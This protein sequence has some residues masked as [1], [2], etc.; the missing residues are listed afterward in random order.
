MGDRHIT[1]TQIFIDL[2]GERAE[3][4][5]SCFIHDKP[6]RVGIF[7]PALLLEF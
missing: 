3:K 6:E 2:V 7:A 4:N 1:E 5:A